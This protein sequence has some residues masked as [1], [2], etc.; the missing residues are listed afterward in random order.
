MAI[1]RRILKLSILGFFALGLT[2]FAFNF[3]SVW[4]GSRNTFEGDAEAA[5]IL[6]AAQYNGEPS[7]VLASRLATGGDLWLEERV[8][9]VV[10]TGGG[11]EGDIT[12][13]A[14]TGFDFLSAG[15]WTI[16]GDQL[17]LE[18]EGTS[19]FQSL[20]S[21]AFVLGQRELD[22]IIVVTDPF[23]GKRSE[24]VAE[25]LGLN[26]EIV[27]TENGDA[28]IRSLFRESLLVSVGRIVSFRRLDNQLNP[29]ESS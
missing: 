29:P 28:S 27:V 9:I 8:G 13:E 22:E 18:V 23:H 3:F 24:L 1:N 5:V 26:A 11:A 20:S 17:L 7:P 12:T 10:V 4:N 2:Y 19:T 16:P 15:R 21:A 14:K 25:E 6:G